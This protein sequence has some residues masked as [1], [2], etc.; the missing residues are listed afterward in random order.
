MKA[1][2]FWRMPFKEK[3]IF[4]INFWLLGIAK[5]AIQLMSYKRL[6][7]YFGHSCKMLVAS[8]L[9][10]QKQIQQALFIRRTILRAA[11]YTPWNSNCLP[12]ALVAKFWCQRYKIPYLFF[13]GLAKK[14]DL[15]LGRDAHAW[16]TAGAV[17]I[18]GGH[19]LETHHVICSYSSEFVKP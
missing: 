18:T 1:L 6:S 16:I 4:F 7:G 19:C 13:I 2:T 8:T 14:S 12:Q 17:A 11:R 10:S 9:I 3:A 15:P 5:L